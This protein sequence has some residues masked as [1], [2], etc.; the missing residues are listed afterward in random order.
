[1]SKTKLKGI[2]LAAFVAM[3]ALGIA[4]CGD[5][6]ADTSATTAQSDAAMKEADAMKQANIVV[7]A[8]KEKDLATLVT[9]VK[10]AELVDTLQA[11]GPYTVFAPTNAAFADLPKGTL[12]T[13]LKPENKGDL[14]NILTYHVV[15]GDVKAADLKDG[16]K[17]TTV[18]GEELT[19]KI[20]GATVS[21][22]GA[23]STAKVVIP[24]VEAS[25]G[26]VHV[27]DTVLL[28]KS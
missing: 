2:L 12:D 19:V 26:T 7:V 11:K 13:L 4:G 18:Q 25:N 17:L 27:I 1:M 14:A 21:I 5:D 16:Q 23:G 3:L 9:A 6:K 28:P 22:V 20:D 15:A 10:A 8:S 24:D